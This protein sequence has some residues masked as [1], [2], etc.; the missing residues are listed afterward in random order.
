MLDARAHVYM[1]QAIRHQAEMDSDF[2]DFCSRAPSDVA[3]QAM[4]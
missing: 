3:G 1:A 2:D 4:Q